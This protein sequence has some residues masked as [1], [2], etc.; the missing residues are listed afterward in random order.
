[1]RKYFFV[2]MAVAIVV[3]AAAPSMAARTIRTG[4][5][6]GS[7]SYTDTTPDP[8]VDTGGSATEHCHGALP[9]APTDVND[10][11]IKVPGPGTLKVAGHNA[12]DWAMEVRDSKGNVLAGSD[13]MLPTDAE[14]TTAYLS[15]AGTYDVVYCNLT[16]EPQVTADYSFAPGH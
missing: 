9:S 6:K 2:L 10:H 16:G 7:L 12:L 4:S 15:K 8:T 13:G 14:G 5:L 3:L 11:K 1:M